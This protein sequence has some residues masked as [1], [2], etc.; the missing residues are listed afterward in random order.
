MLA[1]AVDSTSSNLY[2]AFKV[3]VG[4]TIIL[5]PVNESEF[6]RCSLIFFCAASVVDKYEASVLLKSASKES[7][8]QN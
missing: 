1:A 3:D 8:K 5:T 2:F 6:W 7:V 4:S